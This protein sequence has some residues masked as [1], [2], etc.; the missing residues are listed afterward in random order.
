MMYMILNVSEYL[1]DK[2]ACKISFIGDKYDRLQII[3][4]I[5]KYNYDYCMG[6]INLKRKG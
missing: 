4:L 6:I 1:S 2:C 5:D 3:I